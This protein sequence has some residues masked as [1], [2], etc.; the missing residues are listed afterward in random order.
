V[1]KPP[2]RVGL[3]RSESVYGWARSLVRDRLLF[4]MTGAGAF[5]PG[6]QKIIPDTEN[7]ISGAAQV[8][9]DRGADV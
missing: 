6:K 7:R 1:E 2:Q 8:I 3:D 9:I 5:D 4:F